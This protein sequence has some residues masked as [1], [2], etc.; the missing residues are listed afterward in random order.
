M[1]SRSNGRNNT[2]SRTKSNSFALFDDNIAATKCSNNIDLSS[3]NNKKDKEADI[4]KQTGSQHV[5]E[6]P[7]S[8]ELGN[9]EIRHQAKR[10]FRSL[11]IDKDNSGSE[12]HSVDVEGQS[13]A[14]TNRRHKQTGI[15]LQ[16]I[17]ENDNRSISGT[18]RNKR[19]IQKNERRTGIHENNNTDT[20]NIN[21][22]SYPV[23]Q[24][25]ITDKLQSYN[26]L[27]TPKEIDS[28]VSEVI[29][30]GKRYKVSSWSI[31]GDQYIQGLDSLF[32]V[33]KY[34]Y[35]KKKDG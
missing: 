32:L 23:G 13:C 9:K 34:K 18:K 3:K 4:N 16:N 12:S 22:N 35:K 19:Q 31:R 8:P 7:E 5:D 14:K 1:K 15:E 10:G 6:K 25:E 21:Y 2:S 24:F 20:K 30:E 26:I 17:T 27:T 29:I 33:Y 28:F 11:K